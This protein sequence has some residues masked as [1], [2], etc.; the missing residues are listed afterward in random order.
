M[1]TRGGILIIGGLIALSACSGGGESGATTTVA[2]AITTAAP[3]ATEPA[4]T[5]TSTTEPVA[6]TT[7]A[8]TTTVAPTTTEATTTTTTIDPNDE[9]ALSASAL[10][11]LSDMPD[12][13]IETPFDPATDGPDDQDRETLAA[14][15]ECLGVDP[16]LLGEEV[17]GDTLN[18]SSSFESPDEA[19]GVQQEIGFAETE[20]V[21][22]ASMA[23]LASPTLAECYDQAATASFEEAKLTDPV[24]ANVTLLSLEALMIDLT[25]LAEPSEAVWLTITIELDYDGQ[26][27]DQYLDLLFLRDGRVMSQLELS[28]IG[29]EFPGEEIDPIVTRTIELMEGISVAADG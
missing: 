22:L 23:A 2:A 24:L 27:L 29:A 15:G 1:G 9:V 4:T 26:P 17:V 18:E 11:Q 25:G 10:L 14:I 20:E 12:G 8:T 3:V 19:F 13:W 5:T 7:E 21:A 16:A 6:T 28:A